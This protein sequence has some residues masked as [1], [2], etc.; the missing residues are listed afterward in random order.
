MKVCKKCWK[1]KGLGEFYASKTNVDGKQGSC[2]GCFLKKN[3]EHSQIPEVKARHRELHRTPE[4][5]A[6]KNARQKEF[7][8]IP[9]VKARNNERQRTPEGRAI[10]R[11]WHKKRYHN[12]PLFRFA[13]NMRRRVLLGLKGQ[14]KSEKTEW[15]LDCTFEEAWE[16][17]L[18]P[19]FRYPMTRENL[20]EVWEVDHIIPVGSFDLSDPEQVK[21]CFHHSNL[22]PLFI[23]E[24]RAKRDKTP[25]EWASYCALN[26]IKGGKY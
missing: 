8:Q 2:K 22:Q 10:R 11:K 9:E 17:D 21:A 5:K 1:V 18:V 26:A 14:N 13:C 25:D 23:H 4:A 16:T 12:D 15:Y 19:K 7:R 3:R 20:G 6:R 24:N